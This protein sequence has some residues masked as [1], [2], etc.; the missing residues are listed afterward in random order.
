VRGE[1]LL[2]IELAAAAALGILALRLVALFRLASGVRAAHAELV[3]SLSEGSGALQRPRLGRL[4]REGPYTEPAF[5]LLRASEL[6]QGE[7]A[8]LDRQL[9]QAERHLDR[10]TQRGQALDLVALAVLVGLAVFARQALPTGPWPYV[11][12]V[13]VA[14]LLSLTVAA[15]ARLCG[16]TL[17]ALGELRRALEARPVERA[18]RARRCAHCGAPTEALQ[19]ALLGGSGEPF[20]AAACRSCGRLVAQLPSAER[21]D[22][23]VDRP[24]AE[25]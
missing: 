22:A 6:G 25:S 10:S 24:P 5:A 15:R 20:E 8:A 23:A 3:R 21:A 13:A 14:A 19:I 7:P 17:A 1:G 2:T 11:G 9:A 16:V 4:G 18:S 12:A